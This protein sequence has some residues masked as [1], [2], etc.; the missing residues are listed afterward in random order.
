MPTVFTSPLWLI[1]SKYNKA[2]ASK[3]ENLKPYINCAS[4]SFNNDTN[5]TSLAQSASLFPRQGSDNNFTGTRL[6][7]Y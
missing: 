5:Q 1:I 7:A 6:Y 2:E 3:I 4:S